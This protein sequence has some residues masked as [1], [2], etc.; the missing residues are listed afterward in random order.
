[1]VIDKKTAEKKKVPELRDM[2]RARKLSEIG[3]KSELVERLVA[4]S[5][6]PAPSSSAA[7]VVASGEEP[8][9]IAT[10]PF[11]AAKLR[12]KIAPDYVH[13]CKNGLDAGAEIKRQIVS[14]K[15][16]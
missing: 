3:F 15:P 4:W 5:P 8:A 2:L 13:I 14:T 10:G 11:S 9:S 1:M 7:S 16:R 12:S 6:P